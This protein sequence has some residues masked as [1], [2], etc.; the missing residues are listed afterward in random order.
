M[1]LDITPR[2]LLPWRTIDE[3]IFLYGLCCS[4]VFINI[5]FNYDGLNMKN[6]EELR[7][8][9]EAKIDGDT[10]SKLLLGCFL[11]SKILSLVTASV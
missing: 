6:K 5:I 3:S 2:T 4:W 11:T 8:G 10:A 9:A 1:I 7:V